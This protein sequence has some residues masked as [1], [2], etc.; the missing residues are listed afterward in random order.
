MRD[1]AHPIA[2]RTKTPDS[3]V[4]PGQDKFSGSGAVR[5]PRDA[6]R[7]SSLEERKKDLL[8]FSSSNPREGIARHPTRSS[9]HETVSSREEVR[10]ALEPLIDQCRKCSKPY[11]IDNNGI[12]VL[13]TI[14]VDG[15]EHAV[16]QLCRQI[17][18][19]PQNKVR[20]PIG[21]LVSKAY[22]G[23][24]MIFTVPEPDPPPSPAPPA[25][26]STSSRPVVSRSR[27]CGRNSTT[28]NVQRSTKRSR[29]ASSRAARSSLS[30]RNWPW[31]LNCWEST[32]TTAAQHDLS[33]RSAAQP[34][35]RRGIPRRAAV[36]E[37]PQSKTP[38]TSS[39]PATTTHLSI[40]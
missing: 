13:Q 38:S 35:G 24:E 30:A 26:R 31:P 36:V 22:E 19:D 21:L 25:P 15:L 1:A 14:P 6:A 7:G 11:S 9:S 17:R 5:E 2:H 40:S 37:L 10:T 32:S 4:S 29:T 8:S 20:T 39:L 18:T 12:S 27:T 28:T 3:D 34:R 23:D 16:R 33:P